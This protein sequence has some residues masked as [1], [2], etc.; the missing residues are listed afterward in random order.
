MPVRMSQLCKGMWPYDQTLLPMGVWTLVLNEKQGLWV[1]GRWRCRNHLVSHGRTEV[2][3]V[4]TDSEP[5]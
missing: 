5:E 4:G 3:K 2:E 1:C